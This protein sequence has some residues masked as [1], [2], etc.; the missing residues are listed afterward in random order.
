M[1]VVKL[2]AQAVGLGSGFPERNTT[3]SNSELHGEPGV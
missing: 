3:V 2:S 1:L